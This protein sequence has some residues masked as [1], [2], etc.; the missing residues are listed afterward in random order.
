GLLS[1]L[2]SVAKHVLPH[3]V[4]VIAEHL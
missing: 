1:V 4:P 3:V 2:G